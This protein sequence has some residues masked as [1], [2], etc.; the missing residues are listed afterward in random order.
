MNKSVLFFLIFG[1]INFFSIS[2][3]A[4]VHLPLLQATQG[5]MMEHTMEGGNWFAIIELPFLLLSV[6]F[7]FAT[8]GKMR[9]GKFGKGM[10]LL[11]WGF[12]V[13][14]IGH[15]HMQVEQFTGINLLA[16]IFGKNI[17]GIAW[18]F[19]LL[20]T[21]GLSALGLYHIYSTS[22]EDN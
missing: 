7:A 14:A 20:A 12:V 19:A 6:F 9:D 3:N 4:Q 5:A 13:M 1:I 8:A 11:A 21:W 22:R 18:S 17:G 16:I 10:R 2:A 15:L